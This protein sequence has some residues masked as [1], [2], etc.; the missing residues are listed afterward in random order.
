MMTVLA[1]VV[2]LGPLILFHEFGHFIGAKLTGVR[3]EEFGLGWPPR[4]FRYWQSPSRL[5]VSGRSVVTPRNFNLP[6][7]LQIAHYVDV[8]A[9]RNADGENIVQQLRVLD[10]RS[11]DITPMYEELG[12]D[13]HIRGELS[14]VDLGTAY[15]VNWIPLGGFCRMT[16]EEDPSDP[17]SLAAQPKRE[18]MLVLMAGPVTNLIIAVLLF[19]LAFLSGIPEPTVTQVTISAVSPDTPAAEAGLL[20]GDVVLEADAIPI[21]NTGELV[22]Y[23]N[24]HAGQTIVLSL[25]RDGTVLEQPVWVRETRKPEG[26]VGISIINRG[27]EYVT[28]RSSVLEAAGQGVD[29]FWFSFQQIVQLPAL[30]IQGQVSPEE[31]KPLGPVGISQLAG[32]AMEASRE[33]ESWFTVLFFAGAISMALGLTNLLPLPALDGGRITFVLIEAVRGRRVDPAKEGIVHLIGMALLLGLMLLMTI[34]E[35]MNP[36]QSPF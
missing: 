1:F 2:V 3:V 25:E 33:Q 6:S 24:D 15:T 26:R 34:Q 13:V 30:L 29:Q 5:R 23:I 18:R 9:T 10:P 35:L 4:L 21:E 36:V 32:D 16:G 12:E 22:D 28:R 14:D 7:K 19:T 20:P 31:V 11:D 8:I 17:H 27:Y